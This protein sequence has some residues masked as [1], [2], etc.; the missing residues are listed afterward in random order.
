MS[1][2]Q[3]AIKI[4]VT[5]SVIGSM[6][7]KGT[8]PSS[9]VITNTLN[10]FPEISSDWFIRD[11]GE[12]FVSQNKEYE[13]AKKLIDTITT[14]QESINAKNDTISTLTEKIKQLETQLKK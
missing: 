7:Q 1:D 13:R 5:Q 9:K 8:Q 10:A 3:F 11:S 6:F 2:R 12:M 14:L 4:G